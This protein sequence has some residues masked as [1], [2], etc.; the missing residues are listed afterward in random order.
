M[1]RLPTGTKEGAIQQTD[2]NQ[3]RI[4]VSAGELSK[5]LI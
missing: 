3:T 2:D 5:P 4:A 1:E